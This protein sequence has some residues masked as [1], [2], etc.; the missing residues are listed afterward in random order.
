MYHKIAKICQTI[1]ILFIFVW[2]MLLIWCPNVFA[3]TMTIHGKARVIDG[4]TIEIN[5]EKIRLVCIDTPESNYRGKTQYCLDNETDCGDLAKKALKEAINK[6][7]VRCEYEKRDMYGRILGMCQEYSYWN[8]YPY[9]GT[10]NYEMIY[11]GYAWFYPGGKEC[12][13]FREAF[14]QA[15]LEERG[16]FDEDIGGFKDPKAWRKTRSND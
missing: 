6:K 10:Y 5:G 3:K 15:I 2:A 14:E 16:L 9:W 12:K 11:N 13:G 7:D 4:D 1:L 8:T